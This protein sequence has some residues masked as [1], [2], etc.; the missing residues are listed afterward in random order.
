SVQAFTDPVRTATMPVKLS[1]EV[2]FVVLRTFREVLGEEFL[3]ITRQLERERA[4][5]ALSDGILDLEDIGKVLV[6]LFRP[7]RRTGLHIDQTHTH[8]YAITR[9]LDAAV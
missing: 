6:E 4:G 9:L 8:A 5:D 1:L 7:N 3:F 2:K